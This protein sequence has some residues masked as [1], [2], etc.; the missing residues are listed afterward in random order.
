MFWKKINIPLIFFREGGRV[1][2]EFFFLSSFV[3]NEASHEN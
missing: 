3:K 1:I 2:M